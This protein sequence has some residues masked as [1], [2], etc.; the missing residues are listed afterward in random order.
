MKKKKLVITFMIAIILV[1]CF[2]IYSTFSESFASK[3]SATTNYNTYISNKNAYVVDTNCTNA[4]SRWDYTNSKI[5]LSNITGVVSCD[6]TYRTSSSYTTLAN[7]IIALYNAGDGNISHYTFTVDSTTYDAGYRYQGVNATNYVWFNNERWLIIGVIPDTFHGQ[8][9]LNLVKIM[10]ASALG[11]MKLNSTVSTTMSFNQSQLYTML[12]SY[13]YYNSGTTYGRDACSAYSS[14]FTNTTRCNFSKYGITDWYSYN[15]VQNA[16]WSNQV[17]YKT[18][19]YSFTSIS[20]SSS[21]GITDRSPY[22]TKNMINGTNYYTGYIG[23]INVSDL[24]YSGKHLTFGYDMQ[25]SYIANSHA[26]VYNYRYFYTCDRV[27]NSTNYNVF[28][29]NAGYDAEWTQYAPNLTAAV[30][31]TLYLKA[32]V[33]ARSGTG[34][35][36][37]PYVLELNK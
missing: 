6:V 18:G 36:D 29:A 12:N 5:L 20:Y 19:G 15:M 28:N 21:T 13:Y 22:N 31:P 16:Y 11:E 8:T 2:A 3:A 9:G 26:R 37:D 33:F 7:K 23:L 35:Y 27:E 4:K 32:G 25:N 17:V 14:I 30:Y 34:T 10:R 1:A 24:L